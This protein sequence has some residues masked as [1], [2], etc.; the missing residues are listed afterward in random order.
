VERTDDNDEISI[1]AS[2]AMEAEGATELSKE[3]ERQPFQL[4]A[5]MK[6]PSFENDLSKQE[7]NSPSGS[8]V[9]G[10][11]RCQDRHLDIVNN[12]IILASNRSLFRII[13]F[14]LNRWAHFMTALS[15]IDTV[16]KRL[17]ATDEN[18]GRRPLVCRRHLGDGYYV[19]VLFILRCVDFR[20]YFVPYGYKSFQ[21][22]PSSNGITIRFDEWKDLWEVIILT[23]NEHFPQFA[24]ANQCTNGVD[25]STQLNWFR[26]TS[27]FPFRYDEHY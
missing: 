2:V 18:E 11:G 19:R 12:E 17:N 14:M 6:R 8:F 13:T 9:L 25:H 24:N 16:V 15:D 27:C 7:D 10:S 20:K 5:V 1:L 21:I 23:I 22:S 26:C 3:E 4:T